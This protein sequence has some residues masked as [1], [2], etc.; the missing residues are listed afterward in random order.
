MLK[1]TSFFFIGLVIACLGVGLIIKSGVGAGPWD[2]FFVGIVAKLGLTVG[3]WVMLI[4]AFYLVFNSILSKKRIQFESVITVLLW[5]VIIDFQMGVTLKNVQ[6]T[7]AVWTMQWGAFL[8]GIV[9]TGIGIGIYLT[10]K[11]P[12][13][14]YDGTMLIISER[15]HITLNVSRT[16]LEGIGL[17]FAWIV[18]GPIG[19]GTV[20]IMLMI[21]PLIQ[22]CTRYS[23]LIYEKI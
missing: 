16:I 7:E 9:L 2:A 8:A 4:Q 11:F 12:T 23:T 6:L 10:S 18:G 20:I 21:G 5:G 22:I 14:P 1:K 15:F 19:L 13:M 17:A 3:I